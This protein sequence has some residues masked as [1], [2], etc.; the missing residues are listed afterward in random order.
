M[1]SSCGYEHLL[2]MKVDSNNNVLLYVHTNGS[3]LQHNKNTDSTNVS[4]MFLLHK[5]CHTVNNNKYNTASIYNPATSIL[6]WIL[7]NI[8]INNSNSNSKLDTSLP[9]IS[10]NNNINNITPAL[11]S[12]TIK[13]IFKKKKIIMQ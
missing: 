10:S 7:N 5:D 6:L 13:N 4:V 12:I 8:S 1:G 9:P 2:D 11:T 3:L